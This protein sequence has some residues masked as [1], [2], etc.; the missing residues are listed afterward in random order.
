MRFDIR[1]FANQ[2]TPRRQKHTYDCA[3]PNC[4]GKLSVNPKT[5][6]YTCYADDSENHRGKIREILSPKEPQYKSAAKPIGL[7]QSRAEHIDPAPQSILEPHHIAHLLEEG[8]TLEQIEGFKASGVRSIKAAEARAIG[9]VVRDREG[10]LTSGDGLL[11]PFTDNFNQLRLDL[12]ITRK[13]GAIAKYLTQSRK[14]AQAKIP[15][16]CVVYTEGW[17]DAAAGSLHGGIVTGALAGVSHYRKA[18]KQGSGGVVIFDCDGWTNP[19]VFRSLFNAGKWIDGKVNLLPEIPNQPKAGLCEYFKAGYTAK[20]YKALIDTSLTPE[21]FLLKIPEHWENLSMSRVKEAIHVLMRLATKHLDPLQRS[22]LIKR[23]AR[24]TGVERRQIGA[25]VAREI[26]KENGAPPCKQKQR[27][28][29]VEA[30]WGDRVRF[31][32]LTQKI[33]LDGEPM[34]ISELLYLDL[35]DKH[36][37]DL[38]KGEALDIVLR[39]ARQNEYHPIREY[40]ISVD[41]AHE[42]DTSILDSLATRYFGATEEIFNVYMKKFLIGAVARVLKPGCKV[43]T[44]P[45]LQGKQGEQKSSFWEALA[46]RGTDGS[47]WFDDSLGDCGDKDEKMKLYRCWFMEWAELEHIFRRKELGAVKAFL[48]SSVDVLRVPYGRSV[49]EFPRQS[50]IVGTSNEDDFLADPTGDRRY[51]VVP[52]RKEIDIEGLKK[53]RDQIWAAALDLY[54]QG[55]KWWL[56]KQEQA[57]STRANDEWR[58]DD[59]WSD[60]IASYVKNFEF[61]TVSQVLENAVKVEIS[62]QGKAEQMR[63]SAVLKRLGWKK[64]RGINSA[65]IQVRGWKAQAPEEI[66]PPSPPPQKVVKEVD[67]DEIQQNQEFQE[68]RPPRPP[69]EEKIQNFE[70]IVE[71][72]NPEVLASQ[73]CV[74]GGQGGLGGLPLLPVELLSQ[75]LKSFESIQSVREFEEFK[76][77]YERLPDCHQRQV[78]ESASAEVRQS[79]EHWQNQFLSVPEVVWE[80][81]KEL[82]ACGTHPQVKELQ[83]RFDRDTLKRVFEKFFE[84]KFYA[85]RLTIIRIMAR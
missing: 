7:L 71:S 66:S 83:I 20:D 59:P 46:G 55:E 1:N 10:N 36:N 53:E 23:V 49:D 43:D 64:D 9:F 2:L 69:F 65:G 29:Q 19:N 34:A 26:R 75:I 5:G 57:L 82:L 4:K 60:A 80:A 70:K 3:D 38:P 51:W 17:K 14:Q 25:V 42:G 21:E 54:L 56:T 58:S 78:W 31:N 16:G 18:L 39:L 15:E 67:C 27:I 30:V 63:V 76:S 22:I 72:R 45:V 6:A 61:V 79:Y 40:L 11:L 8:F 41:G 77:G 84:V 50:V 85:N 68:S 44:V 24:A 47:K 73:N 28:Q 33:E 35:A 74:K 52:V 13:N 48:T 62:R 12:P 37:I 81:R 32:L